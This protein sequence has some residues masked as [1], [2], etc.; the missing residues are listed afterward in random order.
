MPSGRESEGDWGN[1]AGKKLLATGISLSL[2]QRNLRD[3]DYFSLGKLDPS[4][5]GRLVVKE[6]LPKSSLIPLH[7]GDREHIPGFLFSQITKF[8]ITY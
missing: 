5:D 3:I 1:G 8:P 6:L 7:V 4:T 2:G